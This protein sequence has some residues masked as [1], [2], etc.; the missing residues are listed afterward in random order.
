[1]LIQKKYKKNRRLFIFSTNI[2]LKINL[3][4]QSDNSTSES[5]N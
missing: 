1:M 3:T 4:D 2:K 5:T